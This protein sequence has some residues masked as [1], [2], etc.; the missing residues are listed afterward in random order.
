MICTHGWTYTMAASSTFVRVLLTEDD[1]PGAKFCYNSVEEH[2]IVH[3]YY[4]QIQ[5]QLGICGLKWCNYIVWSKIGCTT[6]RIAFDSVLWD[7]LRC[8]LIDFHHK[9]LCP[10]FFTC[11]ILHIP[12]NLMPF[13]L[14][15][16]WFIVNAMLRLL[17][18]Q[19]NFIVVCT[20]IANSKHYICTIYK[21]IYIYIYIYYY[22][23][24]Y[25]YTNILHAQNVT[26]RWNKNY[27]TL[28]W[29]EAR[30]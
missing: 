16:H 6:Q 3:K 14:W 15:M 13:P 24:Y 25:Y 27:K 5:M 29:I 10:E 7:S 26:I 28:Q 11:I 19:C 20:S 12:R 1:V 18:R 17:L 2:T 21:Y 8:K 22:Y 23:Y 9:W 30:Q 4:Y